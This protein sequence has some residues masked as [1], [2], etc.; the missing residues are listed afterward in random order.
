MNE[1]IALVSLGEIGEGILDNIR[2]AART[3]FGAEVT[4]IEETGGRTESG[5]AL[6]S[7]A[8]D[9]IRHLFPFRSAFGR[10]LGVTNTDLSHPGVNHVFGFADP[11]S[12][13]SVMSL[14]RFRT[15]GA[16]PGK[17]AGRAVKTAVH[18]LG[19]TYGLSHCTKHKCVMFF[20]FNLSDTD[21]KG[22][23][24]C[25]KCREEIDSRIKN[26]FR[27]EKEVA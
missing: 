5:G 3:T 6:Q 21:Y 1:A 24:F 12:R 10:V 25:K 16:M 13:V 7:A 27:K 4:I 2:D 15:Q 26:Q 9:V 20:S 14:F 18:E 19:H 11:E 23:E 22:R 8:S 17:V